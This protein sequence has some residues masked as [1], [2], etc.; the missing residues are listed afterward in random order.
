MKTQKE[1]TNE[2]LTKAKL[3]EN[4]NNTSKVSIKELFSL[5]FLKDFKWYEWALIACMTIAQI[6]VS[7]LTETNVGIAIFNYTISLAGFLYVVCASRCSFWIFIF[8]LY[9]P[10]GYG[11]VC[12]TSGV[13]GEMLVNF[14]YFAPMQVVGM[15]LWIKN[16]LIKKNQPNVDNTL[17]NVKRLRPK[18]YL[19]ILPIVAVCYV[20]VYFILALL[21]GQR[22][23]YLD[24]FISVLCILGTLLLTLRYVENWYVYLIVNLSSSVLWG[25]SMF[26]DDVSAPFMFILYITY[27][28]Y[29]V[30][31]LFEWRKFAKLEAQVQNDN[32]NNSSQTTIN[33]NDDK[34]IETKNN[35]KKLDIDKQND[36]D[37]IDP[38]NEI[39]G[40]KDTVE[41]I[42]NEI[43]AL[44]PTKENKTQ[45]KK[46][47]QKTTK[48]HKQE[49]AD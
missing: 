30:I 44:N 17:V 5:S 36:N 13:Y 48:A 41:N 16:Y 12:L 10:I 19:I 24:A 23:P 15:S 22:L 25:I 32:A 42:S 39:K 37:N 38:N 34:M 45:N 46:S 49:N 47:K 3:Y 4:N 28:L 2:K 35:D 8:G 6:I 43:N 27:T 1:K 14:A 31:G 26:Q 20:A 29:S 9:Q 21:N 7:I 33:E 40:I 11:I 18:D